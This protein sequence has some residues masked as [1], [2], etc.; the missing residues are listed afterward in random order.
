[1]VSTTATPQPGVKTLTFSA[2]QV[3]DGA[4]LASIRSMMA[5]TQARYGKR[6]VDQEMKKVEEV[7]LHELAHHNVADQYGLAS[8]QIEFHFSDPKSGLKPVSLLSAMTGVSMPKV[9]PN[10]SLSQ[11]KL[12]LKQLQGAA[13]AALAPKRLEGTVSNQV[14]EPSHQDKLVAKEAGQAAENAKALIAK[15][16]AEE[17]RLSLQ[18]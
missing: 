4:H 2:T 7:G 14:S 12:T 1:V 8:D 6:V 10:M 16:Q 15:K 5:P 9:N 3:K 18:A 13:F 17:P 11:L